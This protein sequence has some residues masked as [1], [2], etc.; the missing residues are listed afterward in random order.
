M[1]HQLNNTLFNK[2]RKKGFLP[3]HAAEVGVYYPETSNIYN[4]IINN[5]RCTL[6]EPDPDSINRIRKHFAGRD[7]IELHTV[8][9]CDYTGTVDLVQRGASTFSSTLES[10]P[11][12]VN[13]GYIVEDEDKF[14]VEATTF[15]QI[16]DGSIDLLSVDIEGG[17]WFVIKHMISR[18]AIISIETHGAA[19]INPHID[20]IQNW[21]NENSYTPWYRDNSDTVYVRKNTVTIGLLDRAKLFIKNMHLS[22]RRA[23]KKLK[24]FLKSL[25]K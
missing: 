12:I 13:D 16:D 4:F 5:I 2:L 10:S 7:N 21:M 14:T 17:E 19:Y 20:Q 22:F 3:A 6:I 23:K 1:N 18:P 25:F 8:A 15:D 24:L 9:L 11:S